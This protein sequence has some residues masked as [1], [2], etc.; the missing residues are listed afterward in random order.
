MTY[1][2]SFCWCSQC[3]GDCWQKRHNPNLMTRLSQLLT[4]VHFQYTSLSYIRLCYIVY[5][6]SQYPN[7]ETEPETGTHKLLRRL[8]HSLYEAKC[9]TLCFLLKAHR[10]LSAGLWSGNY[11]LAHFHWLLKRYEWITEVFFVSL[12]AIASTTCQVGNVMITF[13]LFLHLHWQDSEDLG[14]E[15]GAA[16]LTRITQLVNDTIAADSTLDAAPLT[17]KDVLLAID[18]G[19]SKGGATGRHWVLD[20]IDGTRG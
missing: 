15:T 9:G 13:F 6:C 14:T 7:P 8:L 3:R 2:P 1:L 17:T 10:R 4:M 5:V 12:D 11:R 18:K 20:P 16:M 19:R